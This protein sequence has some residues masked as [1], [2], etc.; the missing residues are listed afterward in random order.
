[1]A[2][3]KTFLIFL[4]YF[5]KGLKKGFLDIFIVPFDHNLPLPENSIEELFK[6]IPLFEK[7]KLN[8]FITD[9]TILGLY[10]EDKFI[11]H[12]NDIDIALVD[13]KKIFKL[14]FLL[15]ISGWKP[16]RILIKNFHI[17]QLILHKKKVIIDFCNWKKSGKDIIFKGPELKGYRLQKS[18]FYTPTK[19]KLKDGREYI[20]HSH[21]KDWLV[22]RY[23]NTWNIPKIAKTDWME[24]AEDIIIP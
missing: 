6:L 23:G 16:M 12:D 5:Y 3:Y 18:K 2:P 10:R 13:S 1:M 8:Y 17:Y 7:I 22:M 4:K 15:L 20:S 11:R 21:I 14:L 24:E 19:Y 9:G